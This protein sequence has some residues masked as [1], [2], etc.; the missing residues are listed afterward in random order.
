MKENRNLEVI[1][2]DSK[3]SHQELHDALETLVPLVEDER[4]RIAKEMDW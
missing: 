2:Y 4:T 3:N 1:T